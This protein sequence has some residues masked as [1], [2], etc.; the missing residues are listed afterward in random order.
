M[1]KIVVKK[2]SAVFRQA[3]EMGKDFHVDRQFRKQIP[4]VRQNYSMQEV[5]KWTF[6]PTARVTVWVEVD[7]SQEEAQWCIKDRSLDDRH[8]YFKAPTPARLEAMRSAIR[9]LHR[10]SKA[11]AKKPS[12]AKVV[13]SET[14]AADHMRNRKDVI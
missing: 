1:A 14:N 12:G 9:E 6:L 8:T 5:K 7:G 13:S 10:A 3:L 11:A 4:G 2:T